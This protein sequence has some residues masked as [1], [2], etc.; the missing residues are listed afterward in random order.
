MFGLSYISPNRFICRGS[1]GL[2]KG[3]WSV[4]RSVGGCRGAFC[5][6]NTIQN[7]ADLQKH[8]VKLTKTWNFSIP[9][10]RG[11]T[12]MSWGL[13]WSPWPCWYILII[14]QHISKYINIG[15][16]QNSM[17]RP[18]LK[19]NSFMN[20]AICQWNLMTFSRDIL[21]F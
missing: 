16:I 9:F 6:V 13:P 19:M 20:K 21:T 18:G 14:Y 11:T 17:K 10:E 5:M 7:E 2:A 12:F 3:P 1:H 8:R 15:H 4:W